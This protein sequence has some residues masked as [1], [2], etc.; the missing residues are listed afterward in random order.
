MP[1]RRARGTYAVLAALIVLVT[2]PGHESA[3]APESDR[4]IELVGAVLNAGQSSAQYGYISLVNGVP[5][6]FTGSPNNETTARL[7][8]YSETTTV[9]VIN[10]GPLRIV[11]REGTMTIYLNDRP[12]GDF[13][14]PA[15]FR[16]GTPVMA[17]ALRHQVILDTTTNQFTTVFVN[18]IRSSSGFT[19]AGRQCDLGKPGQ[20]FGLTVFGRPS[21]SG[22]GQFVIA[23]YTSGIDAR[24]P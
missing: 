17:A 22:P 18:T 1:H 7:T 15:S 13:G 16:D 19:L 4:T 11:N 2:V 5:D 8:F 12:K 23:G 21:T 24:S 20:T 14:N 3:G 6:I 9:R 10:H